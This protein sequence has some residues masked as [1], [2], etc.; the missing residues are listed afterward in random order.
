MNTHKNA[1]LTVHG[2]ALLVRR[3]RED[4]LRPIE[5]AQAMGVSPRTAYKWLSR[6]QAQGQAGLHER[7]SRPA[8]A[9]ISCRR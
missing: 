5:A 6:Y 7:S 8:V 3:I 2:R 4:G 9:R 1:R